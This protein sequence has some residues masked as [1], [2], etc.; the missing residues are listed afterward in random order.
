MYRY[1]NNKAL[2]SMD[3]SPKLNDIS[4]KGN[5]FTDWDLKFGKNNNQILNDPNLISFDNYVLGLNNGAEIHSDFN[6][7][8]DINT[9]SYSDHGL[10]SPNLYAKEIKLPIYKFDENKQWVVKEFDNIDTFAKTYYSSEMINYSQ[11][12]MKNLKA[13][14]YDKN[15]VSEA[16]L[17]SSIFMSYVYK[18]L[19]VV[20]LSDRK[21]GTELIKDYSK[22]I[23]QFQYWTYLTLEQIYTH[24]MENQI[25][26]LTLYT[27]FRVLNSNINAPNDYNI[28][29]YAMVDNPI[30]ISSNDKVVL[31]ISNPLSITPKQNLES[32]T[33]IQTSIEYDYLSLYLVW[34]FVG[35][36]LGFTGMTILSKKD[37][38]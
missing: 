31:K 25:D 32:I 33:Y 4:H 13:N 26:K 15:L 16:S 29:M 22:L 19:G 17:Y 10:L 35:L 7:L 14:N 18:K 3:L 1:Y 21:L 23:F 38:K 5:K 28:Q 9:I 36:T 11:A 20:S 30:K 12:F 27:M 6:Y 24:N 2:S 34:F 37:I 8:K